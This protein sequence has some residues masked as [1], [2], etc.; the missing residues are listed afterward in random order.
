MSE[1]FRRWIYNHR[2]GEDG[3]V[4]PFHFA[5]QT[6]SLP[7]PA[8][9][10]VLVRVNLLNIHAH[11]R[12]HMIQG[13]I[14]IGATGTGNYASAQVIRSRDKAFSEGDVIA[15]QVGWQ[16]YD[17]VS[18]T[19]A[20][21]GYGPASELVRA[22]NKTNSQWTYAFRPELVKMW[23]PEVLTSVFGTTGMTAYFGMRECG[24]LMPRD[25]VL[26]AGV[27]GSVGSMVAQ[28]AKAAGCRVIGLAGGPEKCSA[29]TKNL[30]IDGCIDYRA[31][32]LMARLKNAFPDGIDVFSDGVGGELTE[33]IAGVMNR[34]G[35][36]FAFGTSSTFFSKDGQKSLGKKSRR[37]ICG[38]TQ[39]VNQILADR[40]IKAEFW[41][42]DSFYHERLKAEDDLSRLML[43]EQIKPV[44]TVFDGF[45]SLPD[46]I[47]ETYA[48]RR[49]GKVQ[50]RFHE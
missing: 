9:G 45:E 10:Q 6:L 23:A 30:N 24:P 27:S 21:I 44:V 50:V 47:V 28:I 17:I 13:R 40:H 34:H 36:L 37:E 41:V 26:V 31:P 7:E 29:V 49:S 3:V 43:N 32:D 5:S 20:A 19:D 48:G 2:L 22:L 18:S 14:Q 35:R 46:A 33:R 4:T 15:C 11:T 1:T 38:I 16:E 39:K 42:V 8:D 12:I 25:G